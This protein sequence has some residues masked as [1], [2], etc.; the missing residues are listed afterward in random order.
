MSRRRSPRAWDWAARIGSGFTPI[1][2]LWHVEHAF[3]Q[4][5]RWR[6]LARCYEGS[7]ASA[8][9]WLEVASMGYVL[10]RVWGSIDASGLAPSDLGSTSATAPEPDWSGGRRGTPDPAK[11]SPGSSHR[12]GKTISG[13][14]GRRTMRR[15]A[16]PSHA[17]NRASRLGSYREADLP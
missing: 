14:S 17:R 3:A 13:G 10:G 7:E 5:G 6:R 11:S 4:L 12:G 9:A 2:P 8:K 15:T 1:G 16:R